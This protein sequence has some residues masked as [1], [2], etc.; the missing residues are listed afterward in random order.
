MKYLLNNNF[1]IMRKGSR[2]V[3]NEGVG[4]FIYDDETSDLSHGQLKEIAEA[5]KLQ[6]V[7]KSKTQ[8]QQSINEAL[9]MVDVAEQNGPTE[10]EKVEQIVREGFD[11]GHDDD[12]I[13]IAIVQAGISFRRASRMFKEAVETLGLRTSVKD[14]KDVAR[15]LLAELEFN[16]SKYS[17]VQEVAE[18]LVETVEGASH[19]QAMTAIK[20]YAKE[21]E[22]ALPKREKGEKKAGPSE[23]SG[24]KYK[25]MAWIL[26][27][28]NFDTEN[29]DGFKAFLAENDRIEEKE[30][31]AYVRRYVPIVKFA[32]QFA[33][34]HAG[35]FA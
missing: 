26:A 17:E 30:I 35:K 24:F 29:M 31:A 12:T 21:N 32:R 14:V 34:D 1:K 28:P 16:P 4:E 25:V 20:A 7:G 9:K 11:A 3:A 19:S 5:N 10:T 13:M 23:G 6:C 33:V 18:K 22:I 2:V 8:Y 27:N 15:K